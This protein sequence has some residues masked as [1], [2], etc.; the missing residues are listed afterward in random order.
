MKKKISLILAIIMAIF[1]LL[2]VLAISEQTVRIKDI[3]HIKGVRE[4]QVVGYGLVVGL[5][6]TGDNSRHTQMTSQQMLQA[7]GT[8]VDQSNYIQKGT[9]AAVIVTANI[10]PFAKEGDK[11]DVTVSAMADAK[12]LTGGV[13]VQ[14]QLRA[15]NGEI[16]AVAQGPVSTGGIRA[17]GG[18]ASASKGVTTTGRV[19]NGAIIERD[20]LS[21]IG[22]ETSLTLLLD[23]ADYTMAS[24]VAKTVSVRVAPAKAVDG[25]AVVVTI[26]QKYRN[27]R[28]TFLSIIENQIVGAVS[29]KAKV[30]VNERTGTIVIGGN[31]KLLPAAVAH[32]G[33]TVTIQVETEV[34]Q[35][36]PF[37]QGNTEVIQ[38]GA[39]QITEHEGSLIQMEANSNLS[40][41]VN[42]LNNI[43]V[44]P[45]DLIAILQAL[46]TAGSLQAE[47][48]II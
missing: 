27:D 48:E 38:N 11:I 33:I 28:V 31:T 44:T 37:T 1:N 12:S 39:V 17:S 45:T 21:N 22:D 43:G 42:A 46:A 35:P 6:N 26:P 29:E 8:V 13:L 47:L 32:G 19:P 2:P 10:P 18:G 36:E 16:V 4:N 25:S 20:I 40:D 41:L 5:Q 14:T 7:L 34:A 15:P 23:K 24:R 30:V 9:S 3:T